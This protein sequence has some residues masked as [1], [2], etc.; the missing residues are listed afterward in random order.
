[1][2]P[3]LHF[4]PGE[5][6]LADSV[7]G[8]TGNYIPAYKVPATN[9]RDNTDL[10]CCLSKSRVRKA[11]CIGLLA[12]CVL[13]NMLA[14]LGDVWD[15]LYIEEKDQEIPIADGGGGNSAVTFRE[16]VNLRPIVV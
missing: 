15:I 13:Y 2:H 8:L 16:N 7:F 5:Y 10:M 4:S 14:S 6:L 9:T 3:Q 1:K 12:C 11:H